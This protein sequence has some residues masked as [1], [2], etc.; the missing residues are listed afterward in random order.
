MENNISEMKN[1]LVVCINSKNWNSHQMFT[2][3]T[4]KYYMFYKDL[5]KIERKYLCML[6]INSN[7]CILLYLSLFSIIIAITHEQKFIFK[8]SFVQF[9]FTYLIC[10][11]PTGFTFKSMEK[12]YFQPQSYI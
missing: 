12:W 1:S 4:I 3:E 7:V 6:V 9:Q 8:V 5:L 2:S 10:S 11:M